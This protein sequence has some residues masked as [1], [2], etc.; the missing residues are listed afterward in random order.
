M[1][2]DHYMDDMMM[3]NKLSDYYFNENFKITNFPPPYKYLYVLILVILLF[4]FF[5]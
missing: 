2:T 3:V 5:N 4:L 1:I